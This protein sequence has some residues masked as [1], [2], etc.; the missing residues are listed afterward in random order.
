MST[1]QPN[2]YIF[3]HLRYV[4]WWASEQLSG[5]GEFKCNS[6]PWP[7]PTREQ[8]WP[9]SLSWRMAYSLFVIT[10]NRRANRGH[11]WVR[12][13][14]RGHLWAQ[15]CGTGQIR[16]KVPLTVPCTNNVLKQMW[17][18]GSTC[19]EGS[20]FS[21]SL[22]LGWACWWVGIG[23]DQM[24]KLKE[25]EWLENGGKIYH[26]CMFQRA[27]NWTSTSVKKHI[28]D[29]GRKCVHVCAMR[30]MSDGGLRG[31]VKGVAR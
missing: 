16:K 18:T 28:I 21:L 10:Q 11:L 15:V 29:A 23:G 8:I 6:H 1:F 20:M 4:F 24:R 7:K 13:W 30:S 22:S 2:E 31:W 19:L 12:M 25:N 3:S 14:D 17:S 27:F 26:T 9:C 5:E